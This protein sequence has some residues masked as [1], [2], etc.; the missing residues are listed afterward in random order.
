MSRLLAIFDPFPICLVQNQALEE[1]AKFLNS[2]IVD[3]IPLAKVFLPESWISDR[4]TA[5]RVS[6]G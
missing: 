3:K 2:E 6:Y 1:L 5:A 4:V